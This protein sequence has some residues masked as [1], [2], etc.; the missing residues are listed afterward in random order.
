MK[1]VLLG[2]ALALAFYL[3]SQYLPFAPPDNGPKNFT[4]AKRSL[5]GIYRD[6]RKTFYCGCNFDPHGKVN[7]SSC[8]YKIQENPRRAERL[9]WEHIVPVSQMAAHLSC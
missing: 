9:E 8:G 4:E 3:G 7:L 1:K 6:H 5:Q 2:L